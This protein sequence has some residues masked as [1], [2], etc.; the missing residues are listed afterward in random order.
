MWTKVSNEEL[1][2]RE[3]FSLS[4]ENCSFCRKTTLT[5]HQHLSH[6]PE[7]L[8]R[9]SED[10]TS[11]PIP[12][13]QYMLAQQPSYPQSAPPSHEFYS[14][15][16]VQMRSVPVHETTPATLPQNV[17]VPVASPV[18]TSHA[19]HSRH[20]PHPYPLSQPQQQHEHQQQ[21]RQQ[22]MQMMQQHYGQVSYVDYIPAAYGQATFQAQ[23]IA[24]DQPIVVSYHQDYAYKFSDS[25]P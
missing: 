17:P 16:S 5:K 18:H 23:R 20:H 2:G 19:Q 22:C 4:V 21:Q 10:A 1:E 6:P 13:G 7:S 25:P 11:V 14:P 3:I 12:N 9:S 8:T 24:L 15:Q